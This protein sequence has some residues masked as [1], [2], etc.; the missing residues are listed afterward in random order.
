MENDS[1]VVYIDGKC[2]NEIKK[3]YAIALFDR[4]CGENNRYY[5][6]G[7]D[8]TNNIAEYMGVI[9]ALENLPESS[10]AE[11]RTDSQLVYGQLVLGWKVNY[12][13]LFDLINRIE[14]LI[15]K[16]KLGITYVQIPREENVSD[17]VLNR[18]LRKISLMSL[19]ETDRKRIEELEKKKSEILC[20]L[21][22]LY[23]KLK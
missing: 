18:H 21:K 2:I 4:K 22:N 11:I 6:E 15:S 17:I 10:T 1:Y 19:G 23:S 13:H 5:W 16:K 14:Q 9:I 7:D 20:E 3:A 12:A 8:S